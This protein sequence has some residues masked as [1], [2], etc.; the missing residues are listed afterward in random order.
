MIFDLGD[1]K[2]L[3]YAVKIIFIWE[4]GDIDRVRSKPFFI[5]I[6]K[7][8][9][10]KVSNFVD[11]RWPRGLSLQLRSKRENED[12]TVQVSASPTFFLFQSIIFPITGGR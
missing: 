2:L 1:L 12:A 5:S 3:L 8:P 6:N 10:H 7:V 9:H 4:S 11:P